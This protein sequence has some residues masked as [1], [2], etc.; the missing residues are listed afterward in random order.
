[1]LQTVK[2]NCSGFALLYVMGA[3]L[4]VTFIGSALISIANKD[5]A[6]ASDYSAMTTAAIS[7]KSAMQA[8]V[9]KIEQQSNDVLTILNNYIDDGYTAADKGWLLGDNNTYVTLSS[10][11]KYRVKIIG[12]D[13]TNFTVQLAGTGMGK[14]NSKRNVFGIYKLDGLAFDVEYNPV[15]THAMYLGTSSNNF[16][17]MP[18][19]IHGDVY[20]SAPINFW[21][22]AS[23]STFYGSFRTNVDNTNVVTIHGNYTF[24]KDA[25]FGAAAHANDAGTLTFKG[26]AGF[27]YGIDAGGANP[28]VFDFKQ[29]VYYKNRDVKDGWTFDLV[30]TGSNTLHTEAGRLVGEGSGS[31]Y[32]ERVNLARLNDAPANIIDELTV[33][34]DIDDV[35]F[36]K[37]PIV[38]EGKLFNY[39]TYKANTPSGYALYYPGGASTALDGKKMNHLYMYAT[40]QGDLWNDYLAL[41][42]N[43][44]I[45]TERGYST[46]DFTGKVILI[47]PN[48]HEMQAGEFYNSSTS[49]VTIISVENGGKINTLG[50]WSS[51]SRFRGYIH[52][53]TGGE[54]TYSGDDITLGK[55]V[56][57]IH[58][59]NGST[60]YVQGASTLDLT[61]EDSFLKDL[62]SLNVIYH[63]GGPEPVP[64]NDL[65]L[66]QPNI[67]TTLLGVCF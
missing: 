34:S 12:F 39:S 61:Y 1:M 43:Q 37:Q 11:Q 2:Q 51:S 53:E 56:G 41:K 59:Q 46:A 60:A 42:I 17:T 55:I 38:D 29:E 44:N 19:S 9:A 14:G 23:G 15:S 66:T 49:A 54:I 47:I 8:S 67:E 5:V 65:I 10:Q 40:E 45:Y 25:Y 30:G 16:F 48:G 28:L 4:V 62:A 64:T 52:C 20:A 22:N 27:E 35:E 21:F 24:E 32:G 18:F 31:V 13:K 7:A 57:A 50:G 26:N 3:L 6:S 36:D 33:N 63:P 58:H